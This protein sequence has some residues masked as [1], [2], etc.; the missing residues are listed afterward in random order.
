[1]FSMREYIS[2]SRKGTKCHMNT[3]D[4]Q[5]A[6]EL[7]RVRE[8]RKISCS[9]FDDIFQLNITW[10]KV[11]HGINAKRRNTPAVILSMLYK[12]VYNR[13]AASTEVVFSRTIEN[14]NTEE[15]TKSKKKT[16]IELK[17]GTNIN[18]HKNNAKLSTI[19]VLDFYTYVYTHVCGKGENIW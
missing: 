6:G 4:T 18:S 13:T 5:R 19:T 17:L 12:S 14:D 15:G 10:N 7:R 2:F 8:C 3:K 9:F 11:K 1:M 16:Q